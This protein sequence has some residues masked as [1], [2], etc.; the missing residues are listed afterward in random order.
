M[1]ELYKAEFARYRVWALCAVVAV[2]AFYGF[3]AKLKPFFEAEALQIAAMNIGL[4]GGSFGFGIVQMILHKRINHWTYLIH[5]PLEVHK[6]FIALAGAALTIISI[7]VVVPLLIMTVGFDAFT[8]ET[9]DMRHYAYILQLLLTCFAAYAVGTFSVLN[10]SKGAFLIILMIAAYLMPN[11]ET[12]FKQF[13]PAIIILAGLFLLNF[14]SFKADLTAHTKEPW[15]IFLQVSG[16]ALGIVMAIMAS[17]TVFYHLPLFITGQHPDDNPYDGS[18]SYMYEYEMGERPAYVLRNSTHPSADIYAKQAELADQEFF[19]LNQ[20]TFPRQGQ[21]YVKDKQYALQPRGLNQ[22]WQFS[23]DAMLLI[24]RNNKTDE[25]IGVIGQN[26]FLDNLDAV[27]EADRFREVPF[28]IGESFLETTSHLYQVN[29]ADRDMLV[30]HEP[31]AGEEYI[32]RLQINEDYI[33]IVSDKKSYLFDKVAFIDEFEA[34]EAEYVVEHPTR[35]E[36]MAWV[37]TYRLADG[38]MMLFSGN[39]YFANNKPGAS[40]VHAKLGGSSELIH[41]EQYAYKRHPFWIQHLEFIASPANYILKNVY[42]H[43]IE[44]SETRNIPFKDITGNRYDT[45]VWIFAGF[46]QVLTALL[47]FFWSR[48]RNLGKAQTITWAAMGAI[49]GLPGFIALVL[50][51]PWKRDV[52]A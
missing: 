38:Y 32:G 7:V 23:H 29:F 27:T 11:P 15:A 16:M 12:D 9:V 50:M 20:W 10:A 6:I 36:A 2:L 35:P 25:I 3:L 51:S 52:K 26:G 13:F 43:Y 33:V 30:K 49:Y 45:H 17:S 41:E 46:L 21:M 44:P 34:T 28:M 48:R 37:A 42:L 14:N 24:G 40:I 31:D 39:D 4:V 22:I 19:S 1:F 8:A 5:R 47:A 18:F